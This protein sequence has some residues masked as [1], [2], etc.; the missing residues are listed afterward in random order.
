MPELAEV[1][2]YRKQWL[3]A[4]GESVC[5]VRL[6]PGS[7][8]FRE[9]DCSALEEGLVG[10]RLENIL[11]HGKQMAVVFGE[12]HWLGLHMGMT[13]GLSLVEKG[14]PAR[15][16][17]HLVLLMESGRSLVFNDSRMFGRVRYASGH[18]EPAWWAGLPP[19]PLDRAFTLGRLECYLRRQ[20]GTPLKT[21]LLMQKYFPGIGNWMGDE[22]L[23][24]ARIK[25]TVRADQLGEFKR[26]E[27]FWTI[28]EVCRDALRVIGT[29]W[30]R[31]PDDWLFN[32]RW[33][34]GGLCPRTGGPLRRRVIGGRTTC[35]S[36]EW[37]IYRGKRSCS[38][39]ARP[40]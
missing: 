17:D 16:G 14:G 11:R 32:H 5:T 37:Q 31:P 2:Y 21:L 23:W 3:P 10:Q 19:E 15:P 34:P 40:S 22:I 4:V 12:V 7:R 20:P 1:E 8:V 29:D 24:R 28:C 38:T 26:R 30:S 25:P 18:E 39:V 9:T 36:P 27:L 33:K 13:G 35:W 6:N